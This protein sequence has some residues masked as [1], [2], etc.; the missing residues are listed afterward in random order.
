MTIAIDL[1]P[2]LSE[3]G[4]ATYTRFIS[5]AL[6]DS[7][8]ARTV[9]FLNAWSSCIRARIQNTCAVA[10]TRAFFSIPSK[11]FNASLMAV[12]RPRIDSL[13]ES[14]I[15][16]QADILFMPNI[17]YTSYSSRAKLVVTVHDLTYE[18]CPEAFTFKERLWHNTVRPKK[19]LLRADHIIAVSECTKRDL[20]AIYQIPEER[21]TVC[22]LG[23]DP[24]YRSV[25]PLLERETYGLPKKYIF[26]QCADQSRKNIQLLVDG[27]VLLLREGKVN[28]CTLLLS[29]A[30][31]I[32][33][34]WLARMVRAHN[35][36]GRVVYRSRIPANEMR[37]VYSYAELFVY[38]SVYEGFGLPPLEAASCGAPVVASACTSIL[39]IAGDFAVLVNPFDV[40]ALAEGISSLLTDQELRERCIEN[41]KRIASMY[42][43]ERSAREHLAVFAS[44]RSL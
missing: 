20:V 30:S 23:V 14:R 1:R 16:E 34:Q 10:D 31:K 40:R 9:F 12:H 37:A 19:L 17:H 15:G 5:R 29:G 38:P 24:V 11:L 26:A 13:I 42:T 35:L 25:E 43:W 2:M 21:I 22:P 4:I 6:A 7:N 41:G 33:P 8:D 32:M 3:G 18:I 27:Y 28:S 39:E 36:H 44:V